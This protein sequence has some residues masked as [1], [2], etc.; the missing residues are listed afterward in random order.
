MWTVL[1]PVKIPFDPKHPEAVNPALEYLS[2]VAWPDATAEHQGNRDLMT[3]SLAAAL[4]KQN[5]QQMPPGLRRVQR[6]NIAPTVHKALRRIQQRGLPVVLMVLRHWVRA[7]LTDLSATRLT[8][9][10]Q[11]RLADVFDLAADTFAATAGKLRRLSL[12]ANIPDVPRSMS[13]IGRGVWAETRPALA[14]LMALPV[15]WR[16]I[17]ARAVAIPEGKR[18][19]EPVYDEYSAIASLCYDPTW[20]HNAVNDAGL[21]AGRLAQTLVP[22]PPSLLIPRSK[23]VRSDARWVRINRRDLAALLNPAAEELTA[24]LDGWRKPLA[25]FR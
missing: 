12:A 18:K 8:M 23:R 4:Y 14:M 3:T 5:K 1:L 13:D 16:W 11:R 7:G 15:S 10:Q 9:D 21:L 25:D 19:P 20:V 2:W 6:K 24:R 17:A 22:P